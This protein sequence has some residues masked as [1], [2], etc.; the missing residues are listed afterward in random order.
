MVVWFRFFFLWIFLFF[1]YT[2]FRITYYIVTKHT[3][4]NW[5]LNF[6]RACQFCY[7]TTTTQSV[8]SILQSEYSCRGILVRFAFVESCRVRYRAWYAICVWWCLS[9]LSLA[10][11]E[12]NHHT[13]TKYTQKHLLKIPN[14]LHTIVFCVVFFILSI[15]QFH[16]CPYI[17][18]V[19]HMCMCFKTASVPML[20]G[21]YNG[22]SFS[23]S[24]LCGIEN[25]WW[26]QNKS[27]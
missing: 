24:Q 17:F 18:C 9:H 1:A 10:Y 14:T 20:H 4:Q 27:W 12:P 2:L 22:I 11:I 5:M 6:R 26:F 15:I 23:F 13:Y 7:N 16:L 21:T 19:Q 25:V 3:T 8:E